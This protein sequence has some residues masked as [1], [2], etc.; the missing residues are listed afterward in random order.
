MNC[1]NEFYNR[2]RK[3]DDYNFMGMYCHKNPVPFSKNLLRRFS[4]KNNLAFFGTKSIVKKSP[5]IFNLECKGTLPITS[6]LHTQGIYKGY[7]KFC[8]YFWSKSKGLYMGYYIR[9]HSPAN[10]CEQEDL[11]VFL[12]VTDEIL[13]VIPNIDEQQYKIKI[14]VDNNKTDN[15]SLGSEILIDLYPEERE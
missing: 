13:A 4:E 12:K 14:F 3:D 7:V 9:I 8:E 5:Y 10:E 15:D 2:I 6:L 1:D 11:V